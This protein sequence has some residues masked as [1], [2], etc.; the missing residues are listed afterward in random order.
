MTW[1]ADHCVAPPTSMYSMKRTSAPSGRPY[2]MR[3]TQLVVVHALDDDAVDLE[4]AEDAVRGLHPCLHPVELVEACQRD[5]SITAKRVEAHRDA[6]QAR[7]GEAVDLILEQDAVGGER[8]IGEPRLAGNH[9]DQR[10]EIAP[11]QRLAAGEPHLVDAQREEHVDQPCDL[12]EVQD[13]LAREP[14]VVRFRHAVQAPEIA[15]VGHRQPEVAQRTPER[16]VQHGSEIIGRLRPQHLQARAAAGKKRPGC[17]LAVETRG[18]SGR[19]RRRG[20]ADSGRR[21]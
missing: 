12:F 13:V 10:R 21:R 1:A 9:A 8:E 16:V 18:S 17:D 15:A 19:G 4:R 2:S 20:S 7:R 6:P 3:S 14:H 11:Q 5:E